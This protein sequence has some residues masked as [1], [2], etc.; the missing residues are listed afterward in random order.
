[1]AIGW[2]PTINLCEGAAEI[3]GAALFFRVTLMPMIARSLLV[4]ALFAAPAFAERLQFDHRLYPPLKQ[5]LDSGDS[6]KI[7]FD[8]KNPAH[9]VD[10]IATRGHSVDQWE[11]ALEIMSIV[12]VRGIAGAVGWQ[13]QMQSAAQARCPGSAAPQF[14][15][16]AQDE[17]SVTFEVRAPNCPAERAPHALYRLVAGKRSWFRLSVFEKGPLDATARQQWLDLLASAHLQ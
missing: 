7:M 15:Q 11:E 6:T 17:V 1:M 10:L 13:A 5:V 8:N 12:P 16:L 9:L 14:T 2:C 3:S 4:L